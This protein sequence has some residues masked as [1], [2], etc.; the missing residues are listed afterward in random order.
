MGELAHFSRVLQSKLR[1]AINFA[2]GKADRLIFLLISVYAL[3][4]SVF[5]VL[6]YYSF[7]TYAWD[8]GI[9]TQSLWSTINLGKPFYYT[10][11]VMVNPSLNFFGT[12]FSPVLF[13]VVPIY[14]VFQSPLTL[15]VLQSFVIGLA[16]LPLYWIAKKK[17]NSKLWG[18]VFAAAFLLNP[19]LQGMNSFDFHVEAFIPLFF[20]LAFHYFD[21]NKWF[22]GLIF[23]LL[24]IST[25][26]FSALLTLFL[27]LYFLTKAYFQV[28][29]TGL[30]PQM[31]SIAVTTFLVI[32][33]ILWLFLAFHLMYMINPLKASGL[34]G[35]W[36]NWGRSIN[37]VFL[38]IIT[39]PIKALGTMVNPI[40][41]IYYVFVILTPVVFL[42]LLAPPELFLVLPWMLAALLSEYP[43]YY[44]P[45]FQYYGFIAAQI[46]IAAVY[47]ARNLL[48]R[49]CK[50]PHFP[51]I[52]KKLM[53]MIILVSLISAFAVSPFGLP[54]LS[55]RPIA[56]TSHTSAIERALSLIP[57]DASV[58]SQNDIL[59]HLA[60]RKY[61]YVLSWPMD[62]EVDFIVLD[63][64]SSHVEYRPTPTSVSPI[65]ALPE[66]LTSGKYGLLL[67]ADGVLLFE[68][69]YTGQY[70][71]EPYQGFFNYAN[72]R[73]AP[74]TSRWGFDGS[75]Q[76]GFVI[77]HNQNL[78][79]G[80]I[81]YG[82]YAWFYRG[83]YNVTFRMKTESPNM[84]LT[85]DVFA[86]WWDL[87]TGNWSAETISAK[88]LHSNDFLGKDKWQEFT[89]NFRIE[90]LRRMEFRG[91][92]WSGN[93]S[94]TLDYIRVVQLGS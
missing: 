55:T 9:F 89:L 87:K 54:A 30:R 61:A 36:D 50:N 21:S 84:N 8:L 42:P 2:E 60:Q 20:L 81:W 5:T 18:L 41:K 11:E 52:K 33:S 43:P 63:L 1:E 86:S 28:S 67:S 26:E 3:A 6:M 65:E 40:E 94:V 92:C 90:S 64:K 17:L 29:K 12:H 23:S 38:N 22:K 15:L 27:G 16:A 51:W 66:I 68:K 71:F 7:K 76:S 45:Y 13:L 80:V 47:G 49:D 85:L 10:I 44:Q 34:P 48:R 56:L 37:D 39:N 75:S 31:K 73:M 35:N 70:R 93:T 4:F 78:P 19:A 58:A 25:I 82:P 62:A 91:F 88:Q 53:T 79:P 32:S 14:A 69:G 57:P 72:L 83:D 46:F 24:T 59:A 74:S 77:V